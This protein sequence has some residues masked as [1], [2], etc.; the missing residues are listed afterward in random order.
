[1]V[2]VWQIANDSQI[3]Q[4]FF[5]PNFPAIYAVLEIGQKINMLRHIVLTTVVLVRRPRYLFRQSSVIQDYV[6]CNKSK[7][8]AD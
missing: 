4:T 5:P 2:L 3:R 8:V 1:M 7:Y 6:M